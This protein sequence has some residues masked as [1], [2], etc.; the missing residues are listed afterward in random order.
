LNEIARVR[1]DLDLGA[2][3]VPVPATSMHSRSW[4][5]GS[6]LSLMTGARHPREAVR[7]LVYM[8]GEDV[9]SRYC[10]SIGSLSS[11]KNMTADLLQ[12]LARPTF[13]TETVLPRAIP[14]PHVPIAT[15]F[16]DLLGVYWSDMMWGHTEV[17]ASLIDL[18]SQADTALANTAFCS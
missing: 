9:L 12:G 6:A 5:T 11:R 15:Q 10:L 3:F 4:A 13:V 2:T 8:A 1:P 18:Q 16:A 7:F 17:K 14:S